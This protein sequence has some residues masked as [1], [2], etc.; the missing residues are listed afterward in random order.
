MNIEVKIVIH[1]GACSGPA[2]WAPP[3]W[4]SQATVPSTVTPHSSPGLVSS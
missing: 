1:Q 2:R 4:P 3:G